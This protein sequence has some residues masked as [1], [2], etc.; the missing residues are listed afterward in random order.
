MRRSGWCL[1]VSSLFVLFLLAACGEKEEKKETT[2]ADVSEEVEKKEEKTMEKEAGAPAPAAEKPAAEK[3]AAE[4]LTTEP[5]YNKESA[6][7]PVEAPDEIIIE[8]EG[9]KPDKK[10]PVHLSHQDHV[11]SYDVACTECHHEFQDDE[12]V[13][14]EGD[15]VRR[16]I[17]CHDPLKSDGDIKKLNLAFH[18]N[19]KNCHKK[20]VKEEM[21]EDA[22]YTKCNGC[23]QKKS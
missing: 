5:A 4:K 12:N 17:E 15:P 10:G 21:T 3:P 9:Y 6:D 14:E 7:R 20:M 19:C 11:D 16:C 23:H 18:R 8:N 13:W 2:K 1:L 22:P